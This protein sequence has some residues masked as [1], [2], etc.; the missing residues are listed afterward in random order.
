MR[1]T[2]AFAVDDVE[3]VKQLVQQSAWARI[4]SD[5]PGRGLVASHYPVM[6]EESGGQLVLVSHVGRP[7][8][9]LHELGEHEILVIVEGPHGYISSGWYGGGANVPTWNFSTA[10]LWGVPEIL[11]DEENLEAL[12]RMVAFF[13]K[14]LPQPHLLEGSEETSQYARRIVRGTV[15][16]RLPVTRWE[17]KEKMSQNRPEDTVRT[18]IEQL[19]GEG[20]HANPALAERMEQI[21]GLRGTAGKGEA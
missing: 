7:D 13:E 14:D 16:F 2:P 4:I 6:L 18:V 10:H 15:G 20:P 1:H 17:A 21:N 5:V 11:T 19:R 8:E 3:A 9:Q 12:G